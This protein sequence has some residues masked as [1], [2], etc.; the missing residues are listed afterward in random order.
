MLTNFYDQIQTLHKTGNP[1]AIATVVRPEKPTTAKVGAIAII[2][3]D[4]K[5]SG[6]GRVYIIEIKRDSLRYPVRA[7]SP[8]GRDGLHAGAGVGRNYR[9]LRV[10]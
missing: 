10:T 8:T 2:T 3:E 9:S 6:W 7:A 5:L 1:F 4:S